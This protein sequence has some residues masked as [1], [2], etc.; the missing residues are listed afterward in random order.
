MQSSLRYEMSFY[1]LILNRLI[2]LNVARAF[3]V[4]VQSSRYKKRLPHGS[5]GATS[6]ET[7]QGA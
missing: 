4:I 6:N 7:D 5:R 2:C 1:V 3:T